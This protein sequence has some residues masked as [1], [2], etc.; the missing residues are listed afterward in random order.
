[1]KILITGITGYIGGRLAVEALQKKYE[2]AGLVRSVSHDT[3]LKFNGC[4][5]Y[6]YQNDL[7]SIRDAL[8]DFCPDVVIHLAALFLSEH[9]STD[10]DLLVESNILLSTRLYQA[11]IDV[12]INK[13]V[14]T[15]T[16]W[17]YYSNKS[18]DPV[19]LYAATKRAAESI[20]D[21]YVSAKNFTVINLKL[22]DSYGPGDSRKK[23]FYYLREAAR[24]KVSL[25]MSPG[26][27]L[28]NLI[29]IDDIISAYLECINSIDKYIGKHTFGIG[30][31]NLITVKNLVK[32][33]SDVIQRDVPVS[34]GALP[35]RNR[36]VMVP[37]SKFLKIPEW[38]PQVSLQEGI[39]KMECDNS[40]RGLLSIKN[41]K[42]DL[43]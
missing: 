11:M 3:A 19:N 25:G 6:E 42:V 40:I 10:V 23:L 16:S 9:K 43:I 21:Y 26:D 1:M 7:E 34:F 32:C 12:G 36:E 5:L 24:S 37:W 29:F 15:G 41:N 20:L 35:Y 39:R 13:I 4:K 33:Y 18:S 22:F 31:E 17:E 27:Q 2:V 8:K 28:I 30:T 38:Q 14:N